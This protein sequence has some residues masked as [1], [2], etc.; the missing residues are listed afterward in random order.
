M[1][2]SAILM[3][4]GVYD[5]RALPAESAVLGAVLVVKNQDHSVLVVI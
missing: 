1:E 4:I 3:K 5:T 2:H